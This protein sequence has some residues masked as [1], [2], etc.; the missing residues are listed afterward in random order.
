MNCASYDM[1]SL[2]PDLNIRGIPFA[3]IV[4]INPWW[5]CEGYSSHSVYVSVT[6]LGATYLVY[7]L[8]TR[9]FTRYS[10]VWISLKIFFFQKF[11]QHQLLNSIKKISCPNSTYKNY[12]NF[13]HQ[14]CC[15]FMEVH[16]STIT[17]KREVLC[18]SRLPRRSGRQLLERHW[19]VIESLTMPQIDTL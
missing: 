5:M 19:R 14:K 1:V 12:F 15:H 4:F 2:Y 7:T 3:D 8:K 11:W 18:Y 10:I 9:F 17:R 13:L 16:L 6:K